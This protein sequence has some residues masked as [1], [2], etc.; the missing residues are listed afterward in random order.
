MLPQNLI[1]KFGINV[2]VEEIK[3]PV[4]LKYTQFIKGIHN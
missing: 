3:C 4:F 1:L 2:Y